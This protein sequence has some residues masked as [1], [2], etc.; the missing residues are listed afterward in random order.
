MVRGARQI[1]R[2]DGAPVEVLGDGQEYMDLLT[3][4]RFQGRAGVNEVLADPTNSITTISYANVL[5]VSSTFDIPSATRFAT[6]AAALAAWQPGKIIILGAET[7]AEDVVLSQAGIKIYGLSRDA[8]CIQSLT[9]TAK[10]CVVADLTVIGD[11]AFTCQTTWAIGKY[12]ELDNLVFQ[13]NV[14]YGNNATALAY[15]IFTKGCQFVG[16]NTKTLTFNFT[17]TKLF[18]TDCI[19]MD[20]NTTTWGSKDGMNVVYLSG[21]TDWSNCPSVIIHNLT[22]SKGNFWMHNCYFILIGDFAYVDTG[23]YFVWNA[24]HG[25]FCHTK[26]LTL[27]GAIELDLFHCQWNFDNSLVF[28]S[29]RSSRIIY[30]MAGGYGSAATIT[31]SGLSNLHPQHSIFPCAKPT[32]IA[33]DSPDSNAWSAFTDSNG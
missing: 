9:I 19:I 8:T 27:T 21:R 10:D 17:G 6:I 2:G 28:N 29:T 24:R 31:G 11:A 12:T 26:V 7:F 22:A 4:R 15:G 3:G 1:Y 13:G 18:F 25:Y 20:R 5:Y 23:N 32:G 33:V 14:N 30:V 16:D